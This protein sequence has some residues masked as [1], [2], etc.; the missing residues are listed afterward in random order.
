LEDF[1]S[2][3][4]AAAEIGIEPNA[5]YV[6]IHRGTVKVEKISGTLTVLHKDEVARLKADKGDVACS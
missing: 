6:R 4:A 3:K 1:Y 2:I 5:L